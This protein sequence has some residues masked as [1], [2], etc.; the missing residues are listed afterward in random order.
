MDI[1]HVYDLLGKHIHT[2]KF[3]E[4]SIPD[5]DKNT[6]MLDLG[7]GYSGFIRCSP[8]EK[9]CY[10]LRITTEPNNEESEKMLVQMDWNGKIVNSYRFVDNVSGQFYV[11]ELTHKVYIIRNRWNPNKGEMFDIV[12]YNL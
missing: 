12:S 8:T 10:L 3:S 9:Y 2:F 4:K 11:D 5:V 1:V 7:N 6:K